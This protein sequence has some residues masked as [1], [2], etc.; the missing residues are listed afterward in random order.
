VKVRK[1][2]GGAGERCEREGEEQKSRSENGTT[3]GE[4]DFDLRY[5]SFR[6]RGRK[7][8]LHISFSLLVYM[9]RSKDARR[10]KGAGKAEY[11]H[12][13]HASFSALDV[14][15]VFAFAQRRCRLEFR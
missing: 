14:G 3:R 1:G 8:E 9:S 10:E 12:A 15:S 11:M 5:S 6:E 2:V 4:G 13:M 7:S